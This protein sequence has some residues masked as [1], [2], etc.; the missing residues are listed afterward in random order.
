[1]IPYRSKKKNLVRSEKRRESWRGVPQENDPKCALLCRAICVG[2][3]APN[4]PVRDIINM[5][6]A[7]LSRRVGEETST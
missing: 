2:E 4:V 6:L 3:I 1:M 5:Y 7:T